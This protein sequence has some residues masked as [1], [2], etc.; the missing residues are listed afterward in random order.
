VASELVQV[1]RD[2]GSVASVQALPGIST[3]CCLQHRKRIAV[4]ATLAIAT[5]TLDIGDVDAL[6]IVIAIAITALF[7]VVRRR[8]V[9]SVVGTNWAVA[10]R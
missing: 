5:L 6:N 7:T 3:R 4:T 8:H 1:G 2:V 9:E 10:H